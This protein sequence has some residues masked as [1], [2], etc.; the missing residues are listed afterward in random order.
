[1]RLTLSKDAVIDLN[2]VEIELHHG[3]N[4][5]FPCETKEHASELIVVTGLP[6]DLTEETDTQIVR[7]INGKRV[8]TDKPKVKK[9]KKEK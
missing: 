8:E 5:E 6:I 7:F 9:A 4:L 3:T 1:M 2:G